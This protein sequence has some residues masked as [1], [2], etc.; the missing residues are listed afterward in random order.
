MLAPTIHQDDRQAHTHAQ[1]QALDPDDRDEAF[2][3]NLHTGWSWKVVMVPWTV[4]SRLYR[5]LLSLHLAGGGRR[6]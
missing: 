4:L 5:P 6:Y 1:R 3:Y 2:P